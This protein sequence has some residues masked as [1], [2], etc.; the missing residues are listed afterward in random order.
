MREARLKG[1]RTC[2]W[3]GTAF[4]MSTSEIIG[5]AR[6]CALR[7]VATPPGSSEDVP[8]VPDK[9]AAE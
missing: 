4:R 8:G 6:Q 3:C 9:L 5:H 1:K 7:K 2:Q